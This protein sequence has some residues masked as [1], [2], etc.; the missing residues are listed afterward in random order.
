MFESHHNIFS[1]CCNIR[2]RLEAVDVL[3]VFWDYPGNE[4]VSAF[5]FCSIL[6]QIE[7]AYVFVVCIFKVSPMIVM[8]R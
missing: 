2:V 7:I 6:R 3:D 5:L 1:V 8:N 4:T